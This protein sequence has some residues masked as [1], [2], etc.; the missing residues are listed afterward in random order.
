MEPII[1]KKRPVTKTTQKSTPHFDVDVEDHDE[2]PKK[3]RK[4]DLPSRTD[5]EDLCDLAAA[6]YHTDKPYV[7]MGKER[8]A[9]HGRVWKVITRVRAKLEGLP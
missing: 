4:D 2:K 3:P 8:P 9:S 7:K 6:V 5:V 1:F